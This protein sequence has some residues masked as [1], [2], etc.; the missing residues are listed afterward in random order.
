MWI[1]YE[2]LSYLIIYGINLVRPYPFGLIP[3]KG[4]ISIDAENRTIIEFD[5]LRFNLFD[6]DNLDKSI[7]IRTGFQ[8]LE[9][10]FRPCSSN[11]QRLNFDYESNN[12]ITTWLNSF[13]ENATETFY[14]IPD[15]NFLINCYY[16]NYFRKNSSKISISI[17]NDDS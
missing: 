6:I 16:T 1:I 3:E 11:K 14:L 7:L 4:K 8:D 5:D 9:V 12:T 13:V 15:T 2:G 10:S 17:T